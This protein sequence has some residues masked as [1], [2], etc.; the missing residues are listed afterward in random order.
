MDPVQPVANTMTLEGA[1][2]ERTSPQTEEVMRLRGG[3]A[4]VDCLAYKTLMVIIN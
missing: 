4:C 1:Q 2:Q 3:G